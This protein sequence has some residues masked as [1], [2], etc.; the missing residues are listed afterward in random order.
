[1]HSDGINPDYISMD[2]NPR[3]V[4]MLISD[5]ISDPTISSSNSKRNDNNQ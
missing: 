2:E 5:G 3:I 4:Q 1:M